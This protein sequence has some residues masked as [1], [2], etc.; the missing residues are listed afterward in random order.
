MRTRF[1]P[2]LS[3]ALAHEDVPGAGRGPLRTAEP[4]ALRCDPSRSPVVLVLPGAGPREPARVV[5]RLTG[6]GLRRSNVPVDQA[7]AV[8]FD[9][10]PDGIA[11]SAVAALRGA[12]GGA[13]PAQATPRRHSL[14]L[15]AGTRHGLA[16][17]TRASTNARPGPV[18]S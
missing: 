13:E 9:R 18:E 11:E 1:A 4:A 17:I 16:L 8:I 6:L 2:A 14:L 10:V 3:V 5:R 7:P 12:G 15:G